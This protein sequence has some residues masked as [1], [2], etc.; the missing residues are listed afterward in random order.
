MERERK[1]RGGGGARRLGWGGGQKRDKGRDRFHFGFS[2]LVLMQT[3]CMVGGV[4]PPG[5]TSSVATDAHR[6]QGHLP[7]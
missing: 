6:A 5:Y 1:G 2:G 3:A 7:H 4:G